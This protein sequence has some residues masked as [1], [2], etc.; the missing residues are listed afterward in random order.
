MERFSKTVLSFAKH[1]YLPHVAATA[2][3]VLAAGVILSFR[4]L[5]AAG[6]A[7]VMEMYGILGGILLCTP[8]F[9][10]ESDAE[11]W[12]LEQ[13]KA[14][15]M[16]QLYLGRILLAITLLA[17]VNSIFILR[18]SAGNSVFPAWELWRGAFCEALFLGSL[19]FFA[20]GITNQPVIGYMVP[21]LYF[22]SNMG[23]AKYFG[24]LGLLSM[25]RGHYDTWGYF[26]GTAGVLFVLGIVLRE[27]KR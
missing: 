17:A 5:D 23:A 2:V 16:W 14:M 1:Q 22:A 12:Q 18:L 21:V 25:V 7:K 26:L 11:L 8:I 10:G 13:S 19:G 9:S 20:A 6:A 24:K 15:P 27:R 4:N 3:F